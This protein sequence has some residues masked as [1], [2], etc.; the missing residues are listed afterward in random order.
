MRAL[1]RAHGAELMDRPDVPATDLSQ[2][3]ADLRRVNRW[4]GGTRAALLSVIPL[5]EEV[6]G[7]EIRVLDVATGS[8]DIPLALAR[9]ARQERIPVRILATDLHLETVS[10]ARRVVASE[11][12][13]EVARA[14]ALALDFA[15]G[16]FHIAM[17]HTALHHFETPDAVRLLAG[18]AR[19][20]SRAV[21][22]TDLR[23][24]RAALA[25]VKLLC[26][27]VWRGHPV[28]RHD[29]LVSVRGAFTPSEAARLAREAGLPS[30][31]LRTHP[32]FRFSLVSQVSG[33]ER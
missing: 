19:V 8:G 27:T 18:L 21:V 11:P 7:G 29:G 16:E 4:L 14:D 1:S 31:R 15:P 23:R 24:S 13:I 25:G 3:L 10:E 17:C 9:R 2:G 5:L 20:A 12:T 28:T 30:P 22:V 6:E 32:V 26:G 33:G